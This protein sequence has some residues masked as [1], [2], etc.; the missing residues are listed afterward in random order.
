[1][2]V[3]LTLQGAG[4]QNS[5]GCAR[6]CPASSTC[7]N[8]TACRCNPGFISSSEEI[9]MSPTETCD[10]IDECVPPSNV[11]C[12]KFADCRNTDGSYYCTCSPGYGLVSG[13]TSFRNESE[14]TCE[15]VDECQQNPRLCRSHGT[16]VNTPGS[17]TCLCQP[18]FVF[19]PEDPRLCADVNECTSGHNPCHN[20]THCLNNM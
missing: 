9:F 15:D 8:A 2:C 16:C 1:L 11:S 5:G 3:L 10:D 14:N 18:G 17:Y 19:R 6:W 13:A 7:V 12:G 20:S 4:T